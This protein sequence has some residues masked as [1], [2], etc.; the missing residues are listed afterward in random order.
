MSKISFRIH[1]RKHIEEARCRN[2]LE[3]QAPPGPAAE[4][5]ESLLERTVL[6]R[7]QKLFMH[8]E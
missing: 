4:E 1:Q 7:K 8:G 5:E 3:G 6:K 2:T